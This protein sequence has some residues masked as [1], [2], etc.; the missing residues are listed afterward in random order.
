MINGRFAGYSGVNRS[1]LRKI[2]HNAY[3]G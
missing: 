2:D 3:Q 1:M